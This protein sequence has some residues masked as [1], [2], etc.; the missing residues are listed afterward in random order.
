MG[1]LLRSAV[2]IGAIF[3]LSPVRN[4]SKPYG[5]QQSSE[6]VS[7]SGAANTLWQ[8]L[9]AETKQTLTS[10]FQKQL[11]EAA[12]KNLNPETDNPKQSPS[13]TPVRQQA[14]E[15]SKTRLQPQ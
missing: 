6:G 5:P 9:P 2:I 7:L 8:Q 13:L 3:Y 12:G 10:E 11:L 4:E 1:V 15:P 14:R